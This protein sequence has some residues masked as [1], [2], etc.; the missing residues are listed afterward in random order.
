MGVFSWLKN[1]MFPP[2][3]IFCDCFM[4]PNSNNYFCKNCIGKVEFCSE[5]I[6]CVQCGKPIESFGKKQLCYFC[7]NEKT[8]YFNRITSVFIYKDLA[9]DA[10]IRFKT[11][12]LFSHTETFAQCLV[13]QIADEYNGIKF[14]FLCGVMPNNSKKSKRKDFDQVLLLCKRLSAKLGLPYKHKVFVRTRKTEKQSMLGFSE[15]RINLKDSVKVNPR[16]D[17][18]G[19]T[20]LLIDDVCT[21]RASIIEYSR[22]LKA[23]GAKNVY[24]ATVATVKN[25]K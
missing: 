3:C 8:K 18:K 13:S 25:P 21:T 19:K 4:E 11:K 6:C 10:V 1:I 17:A 12:G 9:R 24:A 22:A 14:D 5:S 15:R 16:F 7:A 23:A 20:V 2:R